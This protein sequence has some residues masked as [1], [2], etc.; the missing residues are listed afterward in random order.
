MK[1]KPVAHE[2]ESPDTGFL[3]C[4]AGPARPKLLLCDSDGRGRVVDEKQRVQSGHVPAWF[5][6]NQR[7]R[8]FRVPSPFLLTRRMKTLLFEV[9]MY[10]GPFML[11]FRDWTDGRVG[12]FTGSAG[13]G[14]SVAGEGGLGFGMF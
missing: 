13:F 3:Q 14:C 12:A 5:S 2:L 4:G 11:E 1:E 6:R 7:A 9:C 8:P 10:S